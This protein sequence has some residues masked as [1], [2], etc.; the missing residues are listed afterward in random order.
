MKR[1]FPERN[2]EQKENP[3]YLQISKEKPCPASEF[4][5]VQFTRYL[6]MKFNDKGQVIDFSDTRSYPFKPS[7]SDLERIRKQPLD[8]EMSTSYPYIIN[9]SVFRYQ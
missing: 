7:R 1:I 9:Q 4:W 2:I 6:D 3:E 5:L 8:Y